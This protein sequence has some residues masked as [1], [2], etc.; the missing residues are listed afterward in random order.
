VIVRTETPKDELEFNL[1]NLQKQNQT[2]TSQGQL[3]M[4]GME[5]D[6]RFSGYAFLR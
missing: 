3:L 2:V 1:L 6:L 4:P 5:V